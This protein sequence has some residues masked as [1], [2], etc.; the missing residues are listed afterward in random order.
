MVRPG[1]GLA[2]V[3]ATAAGVVAGAAD[4]EPKIQR[5]SLQ[6]AGVNVVHWLLVVHGVPAL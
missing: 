4:P 5:P 2:L 1:F 6:V 3:V